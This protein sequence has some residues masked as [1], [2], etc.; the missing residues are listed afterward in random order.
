[1]QELRDREATRG[2]RIYKF[3]NDV[4]VEKAISD[5]AEVGA[6]KV[7]SKSKSRIEVG[8]V[9]AALVAT[10]SF[11]SALTVPGGFIQSGEN[12]MGMAVLNGNKRFI[13][14]MVYD[15]LSFI[16]SI[17]GISIYFLLPIVASTWSESNRTY[18]ILYGI[19]HFSTIFSIECLAAA[20]VTG[21]LSVVSNRTVT[22]LILIIEILICLIG[23]VF[24]GLKV[25]VPIRLRIRR[26][27][28]TRILPANYLQPLR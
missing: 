16:T 3:K 17:I 8:V 23:I 20:L 6:E 19:G 5:Y 24:V 25:F 26:R 4:D 14:F 22:N 27:M 18:Q 15:I 13:S 21:V 2:K 28:A 1:M 11:T 7:N 12:N 10:V 9:V